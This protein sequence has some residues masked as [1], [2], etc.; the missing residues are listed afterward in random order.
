MESSNAIFS[1]QDALNQ[2]QYDLLAFPFPTQHTDEASTFLSTDTVSLNYNVS[3]PSSDYG[4]TIN[5][6]PATVSFLPQNA[7]STPIPTPDYSTPLIHPHQE[8]FE[9]K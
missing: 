7:L 6:S 5:L 1:D 4:N 8:D 3:A 9:V 2:L